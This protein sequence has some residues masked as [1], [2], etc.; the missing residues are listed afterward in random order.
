MQPVLYFLLIRLFFIYFIFIFVSL[1]FSHQMRLCFLINSVFFRC[2]QSGWHP[3]RDDVADI[4]GN[5][6]FLWL[7]HIFVLGEQENRGRRIFKDSNI[8]IWLYS[9]I[10]NYIAIQLY[11][12]IAM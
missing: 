6:A 4:I 2:L 9:N 7:Q 1:F 10:L 12:Y 5:T 8:A 3:S 11:V